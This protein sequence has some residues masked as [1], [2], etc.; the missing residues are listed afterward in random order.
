M[1]NFLFQPKDQQQY[2]ETFN[3]DFGFGEVDPCYVVNL[4]EIIPAWRKKLIIKQSIT[5]RRF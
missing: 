3:Y 2:Q 5:G 1:L 4:K